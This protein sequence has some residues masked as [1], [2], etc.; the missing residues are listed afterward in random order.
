MHRLTAKIQQLRIDYSKGQLD[1]KSVDK[2]PMV[3]FH[4]WFEQAIAADVPEPHAMTLATCGADGQP[5]ARVVLLRGAGEYG[6]VFFTNYDSRKG[7]DLAE[8]PRAGLCFFWQELERQV[9]IE[10][11]VEKISEA[12]S[13]EYFQNRPFDSQIGAWASPQSSVLPDRETLDV[14]VKRQYEIFGNTVQRPPHWGGYRLQP[15]AIEFW[16]GRPSRLHDRIRYR[17]EAGVWVIERLAP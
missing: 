6:L 16:Q 17:L 11:A 4:L 10:G 13:D 15:T 1:E 8:N 2:D 3:Q 9:R 12:E 7:L 14:L 5:R